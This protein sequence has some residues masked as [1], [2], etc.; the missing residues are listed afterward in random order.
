M[1]MLPIEELPRDAYDVC[2]MPT[3][4]LTEAHGAST[5][6]AQGLPAIHVDPLHH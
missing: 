5:I 4:N 3:D 6:G 2:L 1:Y